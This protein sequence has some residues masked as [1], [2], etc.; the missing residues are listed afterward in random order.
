MAAG[1]FKHGKLG[2]ALT[3]PIATPDSQTALYLRKWTAN[4]TAAKADITNFE[5]NATANWDST[6]HSFKQ[7]L[8]GSDELT[9]T[10]EGHWDGGRMPHLNPPA[11]YPRDS[12]IRLL[13][14]PNRAL[15]P[16]FTA[17]D[18]CIDQGSNVTC[19]VDGV[20]SYSS[21]GV[22][23]GQFDLGAANDQ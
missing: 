1:S 7:S 23:T 2:R 15:A 8:V 14:Y 4:H 6:V 9:W 3:S 17:K 16:I 22:A 18:T 19:G 11:L 13:L 20:V 5:S 12:G 10:L 21:G